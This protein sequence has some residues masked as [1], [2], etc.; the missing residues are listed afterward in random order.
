MKTSKVVLAGLAIVVLAGLAIAAMGSSS[1]LAGLD[2]DY[3]PR[4]PVKRGAKPA[5]MTHKAWKKRKVRLMM[6]KQSRRAN[7]V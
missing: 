6:Q 3:S 5:S 4:S 2:N 1:M 7:R